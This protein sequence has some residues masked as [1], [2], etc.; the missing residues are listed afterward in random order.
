MSVPDDARSARLADVDRLVSEAASLPMKLRLRVIDA[1]K[2]L[3][4]FEREDGLRF[5]LESQSEYKRVKR[6]RASNEPLVQWIASFGPGDVFY[7]IGANTGGLALVAARTH[8]GRVPVV[9]FEPAPDSFAALVRNISAN[10]LGAVVTPLQVALFDE[11]GVLPFHRA[12]LGAGSALHAVGQ[13]LDYARRPFTPV[14]VE[15]V[16][17]FKL[18]DLVGALKLPP[19]TRIKLDV[20]GFESRVL[21]GAERLLAGGACEVYLELVA[22]HADDPHPAAVHALMAAHG[23]EA[24][25]TIDHRLAGVYPRIMDVLF[26]RRPSESKRS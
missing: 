1:L 17:T 10:E 18:D 24:A 2:A 21:A 4:I 12:R 13:A 11:T 23:Y 25:Q 6:P 7:D 26:V 14:A 5:G 15:R 20:D 22:A 8:A 16:A 3:S 9:A 19:P